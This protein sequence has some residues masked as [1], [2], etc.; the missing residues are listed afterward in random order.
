MPDMRSARS[1]AWLIAA[2]SLVATGCADGTADDL[3]SAP[4]VSTFETSV[5][6]PPTT[7]FRPPDDPWNPPSICAG[8]C[9]LEILF[10]VPVGDGGVGYANVGREE[11]QAYGPSALAVT[12]EGDIWIADVVNNRLH[13]YSVAGDHID[14]IDLTEYEVAVPAD[15]AAGP[16]GLLLLDVYPATQRYRVVQLDI[17][18]SFEAA[19]D[20][21]KGLWLEDGLTGVTW[22]P[23]GHIWVELEYGNR[24]ALL[25]IDGPVVTFEDSLGYPYPGGAFSP[26]PDPFAYQAGPHRVQ[27]DSTAG[28]GGVTLIGV[29]PDGS[30]VL[31]MDE[32]TQ[33]PGGTLEVAETLHLFNSDGRR[34]G[35]SVFPLSDQFVYVEHSLVLAPD[36]TICALLTKPHSIAVA[37]LTYTR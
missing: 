14:G 30:F 26:G 21:P 25:T 18:G 15:L 1:V 9:E 11:T 32:V 23:Q 27:L 37:R 7:A 2:L 17:E 6:V 29:N 36:G 33:G 10:E 5:A 20:L 8:T 28:L 4:R 35:G 22:S 3:T 19:Y 13:R 31:Q 16:Y 34:L 24:T 12:P